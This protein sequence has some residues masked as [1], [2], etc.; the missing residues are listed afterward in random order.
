V[1]A[2][3]KP[4]FFWPAFYE[5]L[6]GPGVPDGEILTAS[7]LAGRLGVSDAVVRRASDAPG[8]PGKLPGRQIGKQWRYAWEAVRRALGG[9]AAAADAAAGQS[10]SPSPR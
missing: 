3:R 10:G 1:Q 7:Q 8:T 4:L 9:S 2:G 6:A 5:W